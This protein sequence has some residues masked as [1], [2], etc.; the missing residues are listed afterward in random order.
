V[1]RYRQWPVKKWDSEP[2]RSLDPWDRYLYLVVLLGPY[3][4]ALPGVSV[5]GVA[6]LTEAAGLPDCP[7]RIARLNETG[8]LL[9]DARA[10][11]FALPDVI[12]SAEPSN[13][14]AVAAW[15]TAFDELVDCDVRQ[16]ID[17]RVRKCLVA[18][19]RR[20]PAKAS[21]DEMPSQLTWIRTW[22]AA[23]VE[24]SS[25]VADTLA[26]RLT[27]GAETLCQ[28]FAQVAGTGSEAAAR[29]VSRS[30]G[31]TEDEA[32]GRKGEQERGAGKTIGGNLVFV[33][34]EG[35][36]KQVELRPDGKRWGP[37]ND[38][39]HVC[40]RRRGRLAGD[41]ERTLKRFERDG[42]GGVGGG[43]GGVEIV[44]LTAVEARQIRTPHDREE[45]DA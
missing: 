27:N 1:S 19:G 16:A 41:Q 39:E 8:V 31:E 14:N 21:K 37:Q 12:D 24:G 42:D 4:T 43:G 20:K 3:S 15:R 40:S 13:P 35:C 30:E 23:F 26:Q 36:H 28:G 34:C 10:R 45:P 6:A 2:F 7:E 32:A 33:S 5:C 9:S 11:L 17:S 38:R 22:D 29:A 44:S 18:Y 25:D